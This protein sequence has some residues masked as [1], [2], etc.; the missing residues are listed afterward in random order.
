GE[1]G[2]G[3]E[4]GPSSRLVPPRSI[5]PDGSTIPEHLREPEVSPEVRAGLLRRV[6]EL[7]DSSREELNRMWF[8]VL[9]APNPKTVRFTRAH[10]ALLAR[11][12]NEAVARSRPEPVVS[13]AQLSDD[14]GANPVGVGADDTPPVAES[15]SHVPAADPDPGRPF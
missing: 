2:P 15:T 11:L 6:E 3:E 9:R 10:G 8:Q 4:T 5:A 1:L 14:Q 13:P 12:I 7:D